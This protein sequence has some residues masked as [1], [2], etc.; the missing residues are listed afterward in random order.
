[1]T[2]KWFGKMVVNPEMQTALW[3]MTAKC[4]LHDLHTC[5]QHTSPTLLREHHTTWQQQF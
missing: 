2:E 5:P 3:K 4:I 1:M